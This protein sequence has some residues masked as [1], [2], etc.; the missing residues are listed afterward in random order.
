MN[1]SLAK[2]FDCKFIKDKSISVFVTED[3]QCEMLEGNAIFSKG[4]SVV[5]MKDSIL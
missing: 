4:T 2:C 1:G 3:C 5:K